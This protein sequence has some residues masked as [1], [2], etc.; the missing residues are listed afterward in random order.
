M[1]SLKCKYK[2]CDKV[3]EGYSKKHVQF[4]MSQHQLKHRNE[5]KIKREEEKDA[6]K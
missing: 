5:E 4:L 1:K 2:D 3:I 6:G